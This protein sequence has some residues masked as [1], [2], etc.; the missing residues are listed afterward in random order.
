M[1]IDLIIKMS[2]IYMEIHYTGSI[3]NLYGT[4][5]HF[6][7]GSFVVTYVTIKINQDLSYRIFSIFKFPC[8]AIKYH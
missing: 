1:K 2:E 3:E 5:K 7:S 6:T 8:L 4:M